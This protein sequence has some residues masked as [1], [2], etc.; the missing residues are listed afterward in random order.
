MISNLSQ[1][2]ARRGGERGFGF[3][4][5]LFAAVVL[6]I[7]C[8]GVA[9]ALAHGAAV[10]DAARDELRAW[11]IVRE[12][13][14]RMQ[15]EEFSKLA[16]NFHNKGFAVSELS[17]VA[18]DA[19]GVPGSIVCE[20]VVDH[21]NIYKVTVTVNWQRSGLSKLVKTTFYVTNIYNDTNAVTAL[22]D[23][24]TGVIQ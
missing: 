9:S 23:V 3:I 19:D 18:G 21:D 20:P 14:G 15:S 7:G 24:P 6:A 8:M 22:S 17:T 5:G 16:L 1:G 11:D 4:E 12:I 2:V 13:R 10:A